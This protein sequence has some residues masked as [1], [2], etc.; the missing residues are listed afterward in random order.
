MSRR[1]EDA[2][3][4]RDVAK[5]RGLQVQ[6]AELRTLDAIKAVRQKE[7][8]ADAARAR[9]EGD[10]VS[11]AR[12][13]VQAPLDLRLAVAWQG[14]VICSATSLRDAQAD[15]RR[16]EDERARAT[17]RWAHASLQAE[18]SKDLARSIATRADRAA[19]DLKLAEQIDRMGGA[20]LSL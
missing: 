19:E 11:W 7:T 13:L 14:S 18:Q 20:C 6:T 16:A 4:A 10:Q 15:V 2:L 1:S 17:D 9:L 8:L 3:A 5:L 12:V